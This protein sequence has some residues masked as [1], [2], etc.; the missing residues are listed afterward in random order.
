[1]SIANYNDLVVAVGNYLARDDLT[2]RVP[3]FI[4]LAE[5][6]FNRELRCRQM[7]TRT[8][9]TANIL[10]AEPAYLTLPSDFQTMRTVCLFSVTD[11]PRLE[12]LDDDRLKDFRSNVGDLTT[13][14]RYYGID[15]ATMELVPRPDANY[16]VE[17]VYRALIPALTL[18]TQTNWLITLAPDAYLYG[19]LLETAPYMKEDP[20]IEV[21]AAG[22]KNALEGLNRLTAEAA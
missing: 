17:I 6:K 12:Y 18:T 2:L 1:M 21:W 11:K 16:V 9:L 22:L 8:K 19:T 7:E 20:R 3:E 5:A 14:P 13:Q 4:A 15:S 10:A